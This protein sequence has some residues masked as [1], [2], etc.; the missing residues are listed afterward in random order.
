MPRRGTTEIMM[1]YDQPGPH[2]DVDGIIDGTRSCAYVRVEVRPTCIISWRSRRHIQRW[3][4]PV[5]VIGVHDHCGSDLFEI[6]HAN[7]AATFFA[8]LI[9]GRQ[10]HRGEYADDGDD[11][12]EFDQCEGT[13]RVP[14]A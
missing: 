10:K 5:V 6:T 3:E 12:E 14:S 9:Q 4:P 8:G 11:D 2:L 7:C 13:R 1:L